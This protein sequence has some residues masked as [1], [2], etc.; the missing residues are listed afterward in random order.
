MRKGG[1]ARR[2]AFFFFLAGILPV[3]CLPGCGDPQAGVDYVGEPMVTIHGWIQVQEYMDVHNPRVCLLWIVTA[4]SPDHVVA[5]DAP[6]EGGF[7]A[8]FQ[9]DILRTPPMNALNDFTCGG[10]CPDGAH[11]GAA[12]IVVY[13]D[14]GESGLSNCL[15]ETETC[16]DR[17]LGGSMDYVVAYLAEDAVPGS[18]TAKFV[19]GAL[20]AGYH[21]MA[22]ERVDREQ[23]VACQDDCHERFCYEDEGGE[24][25]CDDQGLDECIESECGTFFDRLVE[26][27]DGFSTEISITLFND[28]SDFDWP[29]FT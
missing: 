4:G 23:W 25:A 22:V 26:A 12:Y 10:F 2:L 20:K 8:R 24:P 7:P 28:E 5:G 29:E 9:I 27:P 19:G 16:P 11:V 14:L 21:L 15:G 1:F 3:T 17:V 18:S 6:V 13:D